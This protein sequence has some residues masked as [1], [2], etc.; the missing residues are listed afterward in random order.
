M[1]DYNS[2]DSVSVSADDSVPVSDDSV[3]LSE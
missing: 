1:L 3:S 2:N